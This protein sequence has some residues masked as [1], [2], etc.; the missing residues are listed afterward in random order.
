MSQKVL[1]EPEVNSNDE[2]EAE[3]PELGL[4]DLFVNYVVD[5]AD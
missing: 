5:A 2:V 4:F 1:H 3:S